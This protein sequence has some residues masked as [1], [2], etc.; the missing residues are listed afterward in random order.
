MDKNDDE[1]ENKGRSKCISFENKGKRNKGQ[2]PKTKASH[3]NKTKANC[4][5]TQATKRRQVVQKQ[6]SLAKTKAIKRRQTAQKRRQR[7]TVGHWK[8]HNSLGAENHALQKKMP[9]RNGTSALV[10]QCDSHHGWLVRRILRRPIPFMRRGRISDS[11]SASW[12]IRGPVFKISMVQGRSPR[13]ALKTGSTTFQAKAGAKSTTFQRKR[14][15][16]RCCSMPFHICLAVGTSH[17]V[18]SSETE[19][20]QEQWTVATFGTS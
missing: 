7:L 6:G 13:R 20:R 14:G 10:H 9:W 16:L 4:T 17:Q 5:K 3:R 8:F 2:C 1:A 18:L 12:R 11:R 15:A 19:A